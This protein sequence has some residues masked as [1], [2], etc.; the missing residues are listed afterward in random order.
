M[1]KPADVKWTS[2]T[3]TETITQ[4]IEDMLK[5][6]SWVDWEK[7]TEETPK[8]ETTAEAK[9]ETKE[10]TPKEEVKKE[11]PKEENK[12]PLARLNKEIEKRKAL[13]EK[14]EIIQSK[15][16][17]EQAKVQELTDEEKEEQT[18]LHRLGMETKLSKLDDQEEDIKFQLEKAQE[19]IKS[20]E[21]ERWNLEKE[22]LETRI[23]ELTKK[24][25]W[26]DWMPKFNISELVKFAQEED[27]FPKDPEKLYK[28]KYQAE[29][30]AKNYKSKSTTLDTGNKQNFA[31]EKKNLTFGSNEMNDAINNLLKERGVIK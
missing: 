22:Q 15:K 10:E 6:T 26:V 30:V 3:Q 21:D 17:K 29:I 1:T 4:Q 16:E 14:L 23:Q 27:Y 7:K 9:V 31:P 25:D 5:W 12:I 20:L 28:L 11:I 8:E 18:S 19:K 2:S 13:E 24:Y